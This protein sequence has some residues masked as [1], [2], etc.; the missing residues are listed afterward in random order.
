MVVIHLTAGKG[1]QLEAVRL[2]E[3]AVL[4]TVGLNRPRGFDSLCFRT[5]CPV[6]GGDLKNSCLTNPHFAVG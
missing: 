5:P 4:K 1:R 2:V 3:D 6:W